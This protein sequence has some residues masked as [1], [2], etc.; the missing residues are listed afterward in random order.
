MQL[1]LLFDVPTIEVGSFVEL[2]MPVSRRKFDV[3]AG[4]VAEVVKISSCLS[5]VRLRCLMG[6]FTVPIDAVRLLS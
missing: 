3:S 1:S 2:V 4:E 5:K 6:E